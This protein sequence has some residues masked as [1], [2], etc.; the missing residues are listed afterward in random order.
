MRL[1]VVGGK[2]QG[3]E[4]VYLAL[5]AGFET[6]VIDKNRD[7]PA[8]EICSQFTQFHFL[9]EHEW[10]LGLGDIDLIFP[11]LEDF[12]TLALLEKWAAH[13]TVPIVL[14]LAA[15][16]VSNSKTVSNTIFEN[17]ELP[18]P[19]IWPNC[20][21]PVVVKPDQASGSTGVI[22]ANNEREMRSAVTKSSG[23]IVVQE[24][25]EGPSF[26]VE[27]IGKP[28]NYQSLQVTDLF[29]DSEY[30]C[31]GVAAPSLLESRF[32]E[33]LH[34][35]IHE[36]AEN[37]SLKGIMDLEV[38]LDKEELK[39]LEIDARFPS[40]TPITV[41][42]STGMNMVERLANLFVKGAVYDSSGRA[43]QARLEHIRVKTT[44][45]EICGEHIMAGQGP[46]KL[47]PDFFGADEA[48]TTYDSHRKEWVATLLFK[49]DNREEMDT[50]RSRCF[51]QIA[52]YNA[53]LGTTE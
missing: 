17:L 24:Y 41:Y 49:A 39:I 45:T 9:S 3:V 28:G 51:R 30:D 5:K 6:V 46:L 48:L 8:G 31:C 36:I 11:A 13:L 32:E 1:A 43:R 2:L 35:Q 10:P 4:I 34:K 27:I 21:F 33:S 40:Q 16:R 38:I 50:K 47:I 19:S 52:L 14:D 26:S 37:I 29:M 12:P 44:G 25:L 15:Y 42:L 20:K 18:L 22:I 7:I 53:E 23:D